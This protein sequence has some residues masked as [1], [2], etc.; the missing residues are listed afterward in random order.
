VFLCFT[1][2]KATISDPNEKNLMG[3]KSE[4]NREVEMEIIHSGRISV[5]PYR[6][7]QHVDFHLGGAENV[8]VNLQLFLEDILLRF[9]S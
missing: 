1:I 9:D 5:F 7:A 3:I 6:L 8:P 4:Y 2:T